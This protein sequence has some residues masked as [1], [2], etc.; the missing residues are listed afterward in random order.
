MLEALWHGLIAFAVPLLTFSKGDLDGKMDGI[1]LTGV[2]SFTCIV[3]IVNI[4]VG[5]CIGA[6]S[7][8]F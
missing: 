6:W 4:K 1:F 8:G 2:A 5:P 7:K 3:L